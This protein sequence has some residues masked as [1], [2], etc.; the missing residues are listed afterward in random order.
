M[1]ARRVFF[2]FFVLYP[3]CARPSVRPRRRPMISSRIIFTAPVRRVKKKR[4]SCTTFGGFDCQREPSVATAK[5]IG[6]PQNIFRGTC[7]LL[8]WDMTLS[9]VSRVTLHGTFSTLSAPPPP[10]RNVKV[11]VI[12]CRCTQGSLP[13]CLF[14]ISIS[15]MHI[16]GD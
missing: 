13:P 12:H 5:K 2:G 7:V 4:W 11:R 14:R 1:F 3:P 8:V 9:A 10:R 15:T 6:R 16:V